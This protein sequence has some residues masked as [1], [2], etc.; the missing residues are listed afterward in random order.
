MVHR[1]ILNFISVGRLEDMKESGSGQSLYKVFP[2][3]H[4]VITLESRPVGKAQ[5]STQ[6]LKV[7]LTLEEILGSACLGSV[8]GT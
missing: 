1:F 8:Q 6:G 4:P 5:V 7:L 2:N 3:H